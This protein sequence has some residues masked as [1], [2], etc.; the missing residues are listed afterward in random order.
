MRISAVLVAPI[1]SATASHT[2]TPPRPAHDP[3][4]TETLPPRHDRLHPTAHRRWQNTARSKP[5]P[6]ALPRTQP[7]PPTRARS[8][9]GD[10]TNIEA[11]LAQAAAPCPDIQAT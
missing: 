10:L 11:A 8:T 5:L 1:A 3:R 4:H 6:Q 7:L 9:N 2:E